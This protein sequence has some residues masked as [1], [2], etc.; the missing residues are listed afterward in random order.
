MLH[1][2]GSEA[3]SVPRAMGPPSLEVPEAVDGPWGA[4][5]PWQGWGWMVFEVPSNI[6]HSMIR[7][8]VFVWLFSMIFVCAFPEQRPLSFVLVLTEVGETQ[9]GKQRFRVEVNALA[10]KTKQNKKN[11]YMD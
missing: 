5:S 11:I 10:R 7:F 3:P 8:Y 6:I 1:A 9:T 4:A 2:E